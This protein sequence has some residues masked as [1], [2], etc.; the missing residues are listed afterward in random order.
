MYNKN[1]QLCVYLINNNYNNYTFNTTTEFAEDVDNLVIGIPYGILLIFVLTSNFMLIYG[2]YK[3]SRPFTIITK[4]FIYLSLVDITSNLVLISYISSTLLDLLTCLAV[5]FIFACIQF[6]Y[7]LCILIFATISFM[8]Y[9]SIKRP[10]YPIDAN[11]IIFV[12]IVQVI[13][14]GIIGAGFIALFYFQVSYEQIIYVN[15]AVPVSQFLAVS[16][17][18]SVNFMSY[19]KLKSMERINGLSNNGENTLT[20]RQKTLSEANTCLLYITVFYILCPLPL[21]TATLFG[22]ERLLGYS[23]GFY[24]FI[25]TQILNMSNGGINSL[26]VILRTKNLREFYRIK[27]SCITK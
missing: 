12:S 20:Q 23:W 19:K 6:V 9:W 4:L 25:S 11:R 27:C 14:S 24:L 22:I 2:F 15:Y 10:L 13:I 5:F 1:T 21:F 7:L 3:T 16:F 18:L 26:I 17:V 8:R